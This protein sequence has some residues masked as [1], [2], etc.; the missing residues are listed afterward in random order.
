MFSEKAKWLSCQPFVQSPIVYKT[1]SVKDFTSVEIAICGLGYYELFVNGTRVGEEFF[2]PVFSDYSDRDFS[3]F[4]YPLADKTSHTIY[5][6]KTDISGYF[7]KG[8]NTVAVMLGNG[9]YRQTRR[10]VEG[11]T[12]FGDSLLLCYSV[13]VSFNGV[14][15]EFYTDGSEI[16][17]SGFITENNLFFGEIQDFSLYNDEIFKCPDKQKRISLTVVPELEAKYFLQT[18][19]NDKII[20]KIIPSKI[21]ETGN[22]VI[23]DAGENITGFVS[24]T[25]KGGNVSITHAE[26]LSDGK[27][28]FFSAGSKDQIS[29]TQYLDTVKGKILHPFFCWSGFRYFEV[30][31]AVEN[32]TVCVVHSGVKVNSSFECGNEVLN[33]LY[34]AYLRTQLGNMHG[35]IPSDC[36][37]RERLGY[38][39]DGQLICE[40]AMLLTDSRLFF[41][42]WLNDI[43]DCQDVKTG[44]VQHTAPL[45]GGGGGPG[46]WGGAMALVP[47][48]HYKLFGDKALVRKYL[49]GIHRYLN[50]M[51]GFTENGLIVKERDKGWCLGD[52]CTPE[53]VKIPE[54]FVNTFY[55]IKCMQIADYLA[56]ETGDNARYTALISKTKELLK[57]KYYDRKTNS[58]CGG[59]QGADAFALSLG[60]GNK[61]MEKALIEKYTALGCFDTGIFGTDVLC[62]YLAENGYE[63]LLFKLLSS[64]KYPSFGFMMKNG[65]TTLW[66]DWDGR[67]SH[68]HPMFGACV[69]Q[70]FYGL[71]GVKTDATEKKVFIKPVYLPETGD[72][73]YSLTVFGKKIKAAYIYDKTGFSVKIDT[74]CEGIFLIDNGE[75]IPVYKHINRHLKG[76]AK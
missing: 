7:K 54:P 3:D 4:L 59:V 29:R 40:S 67:S 36:P 66:E 60:L 35:G 48:Y 15:E 44:H 42:K 73:N 24:F 34:K 32:L 50:C 2:K 64:E 56:C 70:I 47:Y 13:R 14:T 5:Y 30:E 61:D 55:Y 68:N 10:N 27:L 76:E 72:V 74:D 53:P 69:K 18:C 49:P 19:P 51:A 71:L 12:K 6:N 75:A 37:H 17:T 43:A 62:S 46:G 21:S 22:G 1:I 25:A 28:D 20:R 9:F 31:G 41:E 26:N 57:E 11:N 65:A 58:F 52:W 23:Y 38:T 39:G 33:W 63:K 8:E 45:C 16:A